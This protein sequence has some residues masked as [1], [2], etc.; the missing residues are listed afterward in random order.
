M[1]LTPDWRQ[2]ANW[3]DFKRIETVERAVQ[4]INDVSYAFYFVAVLQVVLGFFIGEAAIIDGVLFAILGVCLHRLRSRTAAVLAVLLTA[5]SVVTTIY[6]MIHRTGGAN[7]ILSAVLF[8]GALRATQATFA[9]HRL[10]PLP[11]RSAPPEIVL[12]TV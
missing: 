12:P 11:R 2:R 5:M 1:P 6:N 10:K 9:Y 3:F 8:V 4:L 7:V